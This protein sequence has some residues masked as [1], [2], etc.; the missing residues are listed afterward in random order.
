MEKAEPGL[1][2]AFVKKQQESLLALRSALRSAR[3]GDLGDEA[4]LEDANAASA[5]EYEDD[6]QHLAALEVDGNLVVRDIQRL[7]HVERALQK[8]REGSYGL[9]DVSGKAIPIER[10]RALPEANCTLEEEG[11]AEGKS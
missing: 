5:R 2:P 3:T 9:S 10:L 1:S 11:K 4:L 7:Q 8:I 6:A